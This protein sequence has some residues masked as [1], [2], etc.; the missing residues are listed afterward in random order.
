MIENARD[1]IGTYLTTGRKLPL[2]QS[3]TSQ[4]EIFL[5]HVDAKEKNIPGENKTVKVAPFDKVIAK[6]KSPKYNK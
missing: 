3:E 2:V 1:F 4:A 6:S 5:R